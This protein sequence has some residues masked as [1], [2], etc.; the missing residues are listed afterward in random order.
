MRP[1]E[2]DRSRVVGVLGP[3]NTGKTHFAVE[4]LMA[5]RTGMMGFPLRLLAREV[6]DRIVAKHGP[7]VVAL[8][9][10][11]ERRWPS[12]ARY[13]ICTTEAMPVDREVAFLAVDEIQLAADPERGHVFTDR[14]LRARGTEETMFLGSDTIRSL[15]KRLVPE[16]EIVTR[17]RFSVLSHT[18]AA[19][20][21]RMP[22]RSAIVAFRTSDV[23]RLAE[24][25]R[26][27]KGGAAVVL[28]A[29]SPRTRNAQVAMYQAGEV[30]H[31]VATD[32]IGMGLNMDLVHV[33][34][35]QTRKF[36]GRE[37]RDLQPHEAAQIA[38][39]AGR[40]MTDG[41]F[42]S[43][44]DVGSLDERMVEAIE[45]HSF[46]PL[47]QIYWRNGALDFSSLDSLRSSLDRPADQPGLI[48]KRDAIDDL[49]LRML[50]GRAE[51]RSRANDRASVRLL[52]QVCQIPDFT[53]T[54][55]DNHIHLLARIF[56]ALSERG[57][58][59]VDWVADKISRLDRVDGDID[60]LTARLAHVRT[61]TY[62]SHRE[63]WL[64]DA[65]HW[66]ERAQAVEDR[67]SDALHERLTQRFVDRRTSALL[68][69]MRERKDLL[70]AVT[71]GGEVLIDGHGVGHM[72]GL[73][74]VVDHAAD[75]AERR[76]LQSAARRVLGP[77]VSKRAAQLVQD[78]DDAFG[79]D[80]ASTLTWRGHA[81]ARLTRGGGLLTPRVT[82]ADNAHLD[83]KGREMIEARLGAWVA[84]YLN[85]CL[86]PLLTLR[87]VKLDGAGRGLAFR[88]TESLGNVATDEVRDLV[89]ALTP[90]DRHALGRIGVRFGV[91]NVYVPALL[92]PK[93]TEARAR[94]WRLHRRG[95]GPG[96]PGGRL[97]LVRQDGL[98]DADYAAI[99]FEA[100]RTSALRVDALERLAARL[101]ERCRSDGSFV[102]DSELASVTGLGVD[103][104]AEVV[105]GL[106]YR[107]QRGDV[108]PDGPERYVRP[109]RRS[110]RRRNAPGRPARGPSGDSPFA[111]L[112]ELRLSG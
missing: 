41:T 27:H 2:L 66:Q 22:R 85:A 28:G 57:R 23:Y 72:A 17:P 94:L 39:R 105:H 31:M 20:L 79:L 91:H 77:E 89:Q 60:T 14:L 109:S 76:L 45:T 100:F 95:T 48:R 5:H 106:G 59:P 107:R 88:L 63:R 47:R 58:L 12:T 98:D 21:T 24:I 56:D 37:E 108:L 110:G 83:G 65:Q 9:T 4:R 81:I 92:R 36:D 33:A 38:G 51:V 50:S 99:G 32:A 49:A 104:L 90:S 3:T 6:Y 87:N 1:I 71:R 112:R 34:F 82:V 52:W 54:L 84:H 26:R 44:H 101:R 69:S 64:D 53:K 74:F 61:W 15:L 30:D 10:G 80:D 62:V 18:G 42:G 97:A 40:H 102:I 11:E 75:M 35:A 8:I 25:L 73:D 7:E 111:V 78:T 16:I 67:L 43:T 46:A 19:K 13:L 103:A 29:L 68:R 96:A 86:G 70:A 55:T 93:A